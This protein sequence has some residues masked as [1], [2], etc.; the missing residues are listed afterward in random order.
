MSLSLSD[1]EQ[2]VGPRVPGSG[3]QPDPAGGVCPS[4]CRAPPRGKLASPGRYR[5]E[6]AAQAALD[7]KSMNLRSCGVSLRRGATCHCG[8]APSPSQ[9]RRQ[10]DPPLPPGRTPS[11]GCWQKSQERLS[12]AC[13]WEAR[14][15]GARHRACT[16][17]S[18]IQARSPSAGAS[19]STRRPGAVATRRVLAIRIL[20]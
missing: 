11:I 19:A 17:D 7:F 2:E 5:A 13:A 18:A 14:F 6:Q 12:E 20:A 3:S 10:P 1:H 8:T 16:E 9:P 15:K 4:G